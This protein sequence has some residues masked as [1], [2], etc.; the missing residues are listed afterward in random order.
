MPAA[1]F[2]SGLAVT[3]ASCRPCAVILQLA[4]VPHVAITALSV[5]MIA[6]SVCSAAGVQT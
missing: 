6:L 1:A 4:D 5:L 2:L 3:L